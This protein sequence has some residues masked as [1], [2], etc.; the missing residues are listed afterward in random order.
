[1][2]FSGRYGC[3]FTSDRNPTIVGF[4]NDD[5]LRSRIDPD[6]VTLIVVNADRRFGHAEYDARVT[7]VA[8][9]HGC[10]ET[11]ITELHSTDDGLR[12]LNEMQLLI[13][14]IA[15]AVDQPIVDHAIGETV[16]L[17]TWRSLRLAEHGE[18][19]YAQHLR[20]EGYELNG[21]EPGFGAHR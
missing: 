21:L 7:C 15:T 14:Q 17:L 9:L 8:D 1:M 16:V 10:L 3:W 4:A 5:G 20:A 12:A 13:T 19:C 6:I 18:V 11:N 2:R